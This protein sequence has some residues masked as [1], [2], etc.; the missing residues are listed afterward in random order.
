[1]KGSTVIFLAQTLSKLALTQDKLV[2]NTVVLEILPL[3]ARSTVAVGAIFIPIG[4]VKYSE[5]LSA[6]C[7]VVTLVAGN[8]P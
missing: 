3:T 8:P 5:L 7:I 4:G 6:L 2:V 1:M